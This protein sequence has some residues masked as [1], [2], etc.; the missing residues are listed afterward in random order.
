MAT[1]TVIPSD[2]TKLKN[3]V[4]TIKQDVST[5][6]QDV[7]GKAST[8]DVDNKLKPYL[9]QN[10]LSSELDSG[11]YGGNFY[12]LTG[13]EAFYL[14]RLNTTPLNQQTYGLIQM[15]ECRKFYA[16]LPLLVISAA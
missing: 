12:P 1:V 6:K 16:P 2:I 15:L 13:N 14:F 4:S 5:L 10:D 9:K 8:A 11:R 3:D 7:A